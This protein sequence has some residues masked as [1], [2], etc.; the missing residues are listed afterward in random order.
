[1]LL[2]A[3][4]VGFTQSREKRR[5][6]IAFLCQ[7]KMVNDVPLRDYFDF[8]EEWL[9]VALREH[10]MAVE[11]VLARCHLGERHPDLKCNPC[12]F[13]QHR[14]CANRAYR[15]EK[16]IEQGANPRR[17]ARE[18]VPEIVSAA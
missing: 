17:P 11:M 12:F 8:R 7:P 2:L 5:S 15:L 14:H 16:M 13:R 9:V 3:Y 1:M 4:R 10:E 18:V 6:E